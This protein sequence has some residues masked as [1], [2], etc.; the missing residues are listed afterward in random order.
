MHGMAQTVVRG[1]VR[2]VFPI[3][4]ITEIYWKK[5]LQKVTY[6]AGT[7]GFTLGHFLAVF[8]PSKNDQKTVQ[9]TLEKTICAP[10]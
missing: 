9:K 8:W 6:T 10:T 7:R 3:T 5:G 1:G 4:D 2:A